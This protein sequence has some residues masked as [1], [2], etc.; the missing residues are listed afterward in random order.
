[1]PQL[2]FACQDDWQAKLSFFMIMKAIINADNGSENPYRTQVFEIFG[3]DMLVESLLRVEDSVRITIT[4]LIGAFLPV[5]FESKGDYIDRILFN[6]SETLKMTDDIEGSVIFVF[7]LINQ[8]IHSDQYVSGHSSDRFKFEVSVFCPFNFHRV[9]LVRKTYNSLI[10][11]FL[12]L[13]PGFFGTGDLQTLHTLTVQSIIMEEDQELVQL[14][15]DNLAL[16]SS[17]LS[18]NKR[19]YVGYLNKQLLD[20]A[21]FQSWLKAQCLD[22]TDF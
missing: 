13:R 7:N 17:L 22:R 15:Q 3:K 2:L 4:E 8:I 5:Y 16:V 12:Q 10:K 14:L 9:V 18:K 20:P 1:M 19:E 11:R 6:L 21:H